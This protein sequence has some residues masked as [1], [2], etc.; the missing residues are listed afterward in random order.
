MVALH[1]SLN[2]IAET[3]LAIGDLL[4]TRTLHATREGQLNELLT[5]LGRQNQNLQYARLQFDA[6]QL[7]DMRIYLDSKP[8]RISVI[9]SAAGDANLKRQLR[10]TKPTARVL[11]TSR[12][13]SS[14]ERTVGTF[15]S[16][17][18]DD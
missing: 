17:S 8:D 4:N 3:E 5:L 18:L 14:R 2:E 6:P 13:R 1:A 11:T 12:R 9:Y 15:V 16:N 7:K 10:R